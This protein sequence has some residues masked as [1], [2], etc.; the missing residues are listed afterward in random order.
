[1]LPVPA[2]RKRAVPPANI[3]EGVLRVAD[4][5]A[6][7]TK[8]GKPGITVRDHCL[9]V[10]CVAEALLSFLPPQLEALVPRGAATLAA[11]HDVGK[12]SPGFQVKCEDW[13]RQHTLQV[14]A[15]T[16]G[17]FARES[18]HAKI[19]QFTVQQFLS[20]TNLNYWAAAV[21]AHHGRIKGQQV[22]VC[23]PWEEER[24]RLAQDFVDVFGLLPNKPATE[25]VTWFLA[26]LITV[27]DWIGSDE[28]HFPQD[29]HWDMG[30]RQDSANAA[31]AA[32]NWKPIAPKHLKDFSELFPEIPQANS[33]QVATM[34]AVRAPGVY[35]VEG[36][37]GLGKTE[38]ALAAA[39]KLINNGKACGIYFALP[40]QVTSNRI[41][42]RLEPFVARISREPADVRLVH[43]TSWLA[44]SEPPQLSASMLSDQEAVDHVRSGRS[45]FASSKRAL[46]SPYGV[47]TVDQALLGIVAAKHFFVR[48][49]G[50]AGKVVVLD[51]V[52]TYDLYTGTLIGE[53][54]KRLLE[55]QCTVIVLSAT[56]TENRRRALLG[57][58][59]TVR[60]SELYPL[61]TGVADA[62]VECPCEPPP[63]KTIHIRNIPGGP[64]IENVLERARHGECVLWIR[65]TVDEAQATY[66]T[67][68]SASVNG[69]PN[70]ALLHSRF[71]FFRR[72]Q[73]E[74]DWMARL[75]KDS[76]T[77]PNGCVLV[78]TQVAEQ[79]VDIDADLLV[80]DLAPTDMLLQRLGRL[81]RHERAKRPAMHPAVWIQ[82][83]YLD[84]ASLEVANE[85]ELCAALGK[86]ARVY[87]PYVLLRS[88]KQWSGREHITLPNQI[89]SILESTYTDVSSDEPVAWQRLR[90]KLERQKEKM[91][92]LAVNA[93]LV[94]TNPALRDEEGVQTRLSSYRTA[95]VLLVT[96][97]NQD[98]GDTILRLLDG[99]KATVPKREWSFSAAKSIHRN[100]VRIPYWAVTAGV[101]NA[102]DWLSDYVNQ[103]VAIGFVQ[104]DGSVAWPGQSY[105]TGLSYDPDQGLVIDREQL[106]SIWNEDSDES[107][108]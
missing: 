39:Y 3:R 101:K 83:P 70:V 48:Q 98:S 19:S 47:G 58:G 59:E 36:S 62:L 13:L 104:Q 5:W 37:M 27:A 91:A 96:D 11:M 18:D 63:A 42:R 9:N 45:W 71:P 79:S 14:R 35:I 56:L 76:A 41:F 77:R 103:S 20:D 31:L 86:S 15:S 32:I 24:R 7:T 51:E 82:M 34:D 22:L 8:D 81:W 17:W 1:M 30:E 23:E 93:T 40:T 57:L 53:L 50:L 108:D 43:G 16:E 74:D 61:V 85:E 73:L 68:K 67:L 38:A 44:E 89:R 78:S 49:F 105:T 87:A 92:Q 12:V 75:G 2:P 94:W 4:Y 25:A 28:R 65:N 46:L 95:Q 52:H 97:I 33:L 66:R 29:A 21:G 54:V 64:H 99:T 88:L 80:T 84:M 69:W 72:Q 106:K 10:G 55:L 100:L 107:C 102:P 90:E 6:K 60:L 26:G